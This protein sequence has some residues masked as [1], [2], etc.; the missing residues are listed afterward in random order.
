LKYFVSLF[1]LI[2]AA[3]TIFGYFIAPDNTQWAAQQLP[4]LAQK[5][6]FFSAYLAIEKR[7]ETSFF[8]TLLKGKNPSEI[9]LLSPN[10]PYTLP[11]NDDSLLLHLNNGENKKVA[12]KQL[13]YSKPVQFTYY[14]G[15]DPLGRDI[16]SRLIIGSRTSLTISIIAILISVFVGVTL[17]LCSG[18]FEG[19]IDVVIS[20]LM[21]VFWALPST[22][23]AIGIAFAIGKGFFTVVIAISAVLWIDIAR[24][25]RHE[26]LRLKEKD[27]IKASQTLGLNSQRILF[28]HIL[29]NLITPIRV[30]SFS[31]FTTALIL[32][33][34]LSFLGLGVSP[35]VP[36]WG[37]LIFDGYYY[38]ALSSGKWLL[39]A[40]A[41][42][43]ITTV[44]CL[45]YLTNQ[46][47]NPNPVS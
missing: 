38:I 44:L 20:W 13:E 6:P 28:F 33:G 41:F 35:P 3:W 30:I 27:F 4:E 1:F 2:L 12:R 45:Q 32:E 43:L 10:K 23:L 5:P 24:L 16:F 42:Y 18:Y 47:L 29:P 25:V 37:T 36:S 14:L 9:W 17:G 31:T 46:L 8:E 26:T 39:L 15:T 21:N 11:T 7:Q 34:S 40:P 19:W 22:L